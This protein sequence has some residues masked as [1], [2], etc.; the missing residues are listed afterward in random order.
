MI[1]KYNNFLNLKGFIESQIPESQYFRTGSESLF[2][3]QQAPKN[4]ALK[5]YWESFSEL[6][7][8]Q[9]PRINIAITQVVG[10]FP[11]FGDFLQASRILWDHPRVKTMATD[12]INIYI[13]SE[14]CAE[15]T[16]K[17]LTFVL[18]HE[19][20]HITLLHHFRME[21]HG[22]K[23][24]EKWNIA[25]DLEIN[26]YCTELYIGANRLITAAEIKEMDGLYDEKYVKM[27]VEHI[28]DKIPDPPKPPKQDPPP[29][30]PPQ[31]PKV[32]DYVRVKIG[33]GLGKIT[34]KNSDGTWKIESVTKEEVDSVMKGR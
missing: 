24:A 22:V 32:G 8:K 12:G 9:I 3:S 19:I 20:M 17:Q 14:F 6:R 26:P 18:V 15:H 25:G 10:A 2:E 7:A 4:P 11:F 29:P 31:E 16:I 33:G 13:S 1:L 27:P 21:E 23:N 5:A 28:Y 34:G 30:G